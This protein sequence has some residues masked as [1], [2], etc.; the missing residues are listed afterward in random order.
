MKIKSKKQLEILLSKLREFIEPKVALEQYATPSSIASSVIWIAYQMGDIE[1]KVIADFACGTGI[2]S[3]GALLLGA[4]FVYA[5]DV[6]KNAIK[7]AKENAKDFDNI[8]FFCMDIS[9]FDKKT[10]VV[11]MNPPFGVKKK[12][13]DKKFLQI[14]FH[15][16]DVIYSLHKIESGNFIKKFSM[17]NGFNS[18]LLKIYDFPLK[19]TMKF[20]RKRFHNVKVGLWRY[21]KV[22]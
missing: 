18:M 9:K 19:A 6:D 3:V 15:V 8:A 13:A 5:I 11:I 7:I 14:A 17:E 2:F 4:K 22:V 1:G 12:F 10:D 20:H 21:E 16:S